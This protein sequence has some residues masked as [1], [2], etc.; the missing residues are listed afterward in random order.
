MMFA[1][2]NDSNADES[3]SKKDRDDDDDKDRDDD[4]DK[5][6]DDDDDKDR[7]D[8]DD[9]DKDGD[10]SLKDAAT[11]SNG[12]LCT[13]IARNLGEDRPSQSDLDGCE[14]MLDML[15]EMAGDGWP[16]VAKCIVQADSESDMERCGEMAG[17]MMA[18]EVINSDA[19]VRA[20]MADASASLGGMSVSEACEKAMSNMLAEE[21]M[22]VSDVPSDEWAEAM[23]DCTQMI[24]VIQKMAGDSWPK[25]SDCISNARTERDMEK[26]GEMAGAAF[27]EDALEK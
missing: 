2:S 10:L 15:R 26:C 24:A 12:K 23:S 9:Q 3:S 6:R 19:P 17:E 8:D 4:D 5:D 27:A 13:Q 22:Q 14:K 18:E 25:V 21:G 7:D 16:K 20:G 11:A 1:C